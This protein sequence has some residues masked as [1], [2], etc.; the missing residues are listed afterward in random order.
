MATYQELIGADRY[1]Y[2]AIFTNNYCQV[3]LDFSNITGL[4]SWITAMPGMTY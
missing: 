4:T 3:F 1:I 2:I